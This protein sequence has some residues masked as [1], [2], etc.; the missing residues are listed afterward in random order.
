MSR[1]FRPRYAVAALAVL[2]AAACAD[3]SAPGLV[4]SSEAIP[5]AVG[6]VT[7]DATPAYEQL[8]VCK[9]W[10]G[11][12]AVDID[13][14]LSG[15]TLIGNETANVTIPAGQCV[16]VAIRGPTNSAT[17]TVTEDSP[18]AGYITTWETITT[19]GVTTSGTGVAADPV[20]IGTAAAGGPVGATVT[21]TNELPPPPPGDEGCT[22]G[23]WKQPQHFDS[24][25]T[26]APTDLAGSV[27]DLTGYPTLASKTLLASLDGTGG[28]G[29][30]G[31][32]SILLRAAVAAILNAESS[33]VDYT[34]VTAD[35]IADVNAAL[36][37]NDRATM[38]ALAAELDADNNLGCPLN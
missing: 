18:G 37:S 14:T 11:T 7:T 5:V 10:I 2:F 27:F 19:T 4:P 17:F 35:I 23:Y 29:T 9:E 8:K 30:L 1:M 22:P 38:L 26:Y 6:D 13:V 3:P 32:A 21:F 33:G 12:T 20:T 25:T 15:A 34:Q 31:A 28:P 36:A 24:W 16:V